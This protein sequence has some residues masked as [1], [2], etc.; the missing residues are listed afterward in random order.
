MNEIKEKIFYKV[1]MRAISPL[2]VGNGENVNS[3]NDVILDS[4]K[5]PFIPATSIAGVFSHYLSNE[6]KNILS[7]NDIMS[8]IFLSDA[9]VIGD[10]KIGVRDG[11][12][13]EPDMKVVVEMGKFDW[14]IIETGAIFEFRM[15]LTVRG[16]D[17]YEKIVESCLQAIQL[18]DISFGSNTTKGMGYF[19]IQ[20]VAKE[21]FNKDNASEILNF[22]YNKMTLYEGYKKCIV[23]SKYH[24]INVEL[25]QLG[26]I[27]I[28]TYSANADDV[29]YHHITCNN[30]PVIPGSSWNGAI[31]KRMQELAQEI[32]LKDS[33]KWDD[34]YGF[35]EGNKAQIS[36]V[37][38]MESIIEDAKDKKISRNKI[39]RFAGGTVEHA[40]Y[41]EI[42]T[43]NGNTI[44][45]LRLKKE[46]VEPWVIGLLLLVI[47]D[48]KN[49]LLAIGG[50]T[51]IG[52]G[53]FEVNKVSLNGAHISDYTPYYNALVKK[54]HAG[55]NANE[56]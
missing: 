56:Y 29:D 7:P 4:K 44:L 49:G 35:V 38:T 33:L 10:F 51:S 39:D 31:R 46:S 1:K 14:E 37:T 50:L 43:F 22:S 52:R 20:E 32:G 18:K 36:Q 34:I 11:V 3:D 9:K 15:E 53:M 40:L 25:K 42:A 47:E 28:R 12:R 17:S 21:K 16:D 27:S 41:D 23:E 6:D 5:C 8:P 48:L 54:V 24:E 19:E 55:G 30:Q 2:A 13:L 26:G 45:T